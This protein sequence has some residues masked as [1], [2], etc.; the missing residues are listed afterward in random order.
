MA[1]HYPHQSQ[2]FRTVQ[3]LNPVWWLGN[4]DDPLAPDW[5]RP[6]KRCRNL[7]WHL[8]NPC[9]NF[10]FYVVGIVDKPFSRVGRF[11]D[12][13]SNPN[14]G[15]NWAVCRYKCLRLP[16]IDYKRTRF[17]FYCGWRANGAFGVKLN[18]AKQEELPPKQPAEPVSPD[19][20]NL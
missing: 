14:R 17:E 19:G 4:A 15:W 7:M 12:H 5:Y 10:D 9:H 2:H 1:T 8:R 18:F 16:F 20:K 6:G 11:P 3:K 13:V